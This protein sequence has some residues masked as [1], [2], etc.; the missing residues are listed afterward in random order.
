MGRKAIFS[1]STKSSKISL[2]RL[3]RPWCSTFQ[4]ISREGGGGGGGGGRRKGS[5]P[6]APPV[7]GS[8]REWLGY[9]RVP[10]PH[11]GEGILLPVEAFINHGRGTQGNKYSFGLKSGTAQGRLE[12]HRHGATGL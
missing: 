3:R 1:P 7:S 5:G 12:H 10:C 9:A 2:G 11:I 6:G 4:P 8:Q